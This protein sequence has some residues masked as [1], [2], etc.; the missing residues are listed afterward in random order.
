MVTLY[1]K[2]SGKLRVL[3]KGARRSSSKL[4]GHFEPLALVQ[5]SLAHGHNLDIV[6]Q[7]Q[8]IEDFP[9]LK[10]ELQA[11]TKGLY[12]VELVDGFGSEANP[13]QD[14]YYLAIET[15][16]AIGQDPESEWPLRFFELHLL[17]VS[18]LMPELYCCVEC[19][20]ELV[21]DHHRFSPTL[22]GTFCPDCTPTGVYLRP[23]GVRALKVL[24]LLDRSRLAD[25]PPL[26]MDEILAQELKAIL[27]KTVEYWLDKEVRSRAFL[28]HLGR[29]PT[30][31]IK[32]RWHR[33]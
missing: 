22:G 21:P 27:S 12:V 11:V 23:L 13:N 24:R 8:T 10:R 25:I 14:L 2:D 19:R 7:A 3:A 28:E 31:E 32:S 33:G 1:S 30:D 9:K 20:K 6:T 29:S 16:R 17:R 5:L 4:V 15:L 18:G 26:P